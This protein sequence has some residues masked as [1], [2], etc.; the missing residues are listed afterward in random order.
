[1]SARAAGH[2]T[3]F[4]PENIL[5]PPASPIPTMPEPGPKA[6]YAQAIHAILPAAVLLISRQFEMI[7]DKHNNALCL[8]GRGQQVLPQERAPSQ[9]QRPGPH[10]K[11]RLVFSNRSGQPGRCHPSPTPRS[12][13]LLTFSGSCPKSVIEDKRFSINGLRIPRSTAVLSGGGSVPSGS[14][15]P[16]CHL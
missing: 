10:M 15:R 16:R 6:P 1:M 4:T 9:P 12:F 2:R 8:N 13:R 3:P 7:S 11:N 14:Q 5:Q